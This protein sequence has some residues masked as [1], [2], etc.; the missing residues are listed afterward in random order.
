MRPHGL[1]YATGWANVQGEVDSRFRKPLHNYQRVEFNDDRGRHPP[2]W[3]KGEDWIP[4]PYR[5]TGQAFCRDDGY[6]KVSLRG[7]N[8]GGRAGLKPAP[9]RLSSGRA[10]V[11]GELGDDNGLGTGKIGPTHP[12]PTIGP[13]LRRGDERGGRGDEGGAGVTK[14][15]QG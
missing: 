1:N 8:R 6:A 10:G 4:G 14:G 9:T 5:S 12:H 7:K 3:G 13:C 2:S 11:S 15:G